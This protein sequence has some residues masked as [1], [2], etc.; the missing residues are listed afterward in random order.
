M[1]LSLRLESH[2]ESPKPSKASP[3][4][5]KYVV[6][7]CCCSGELGGEAGVREQAAAGEHRGPAGQ[8]VPH[9][10]GAQ[11]EETGRSLLLSLDLQASVGSHLAWCLLLGYYIVHVLQ[12]VFFLLISICGQLKRDMRN[13]T[14]STFDCILIV[15]V[16]LCVFVCVCVCVCVRAR[17]YYY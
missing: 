11:P 10:A 17:Y 14:R 9:R 4:N 7:V 6:G 16:C 5:Q 2:H 1:G 15:C 8:T 13:T 3:R 12:I